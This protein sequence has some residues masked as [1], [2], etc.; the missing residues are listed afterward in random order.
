MLGNLH[1]HWSR[2]PET[3]SQSSKLEQT[4][5]NPKHAPESKCG[6]R[7]KKLLGRN[8][9]QWRCVDHPVSSNVS[10]PLWFFPWCTV[11]ATNGITHKKSNRN[12]HHVLCWQRRPRQNSNSVVQ[13]FYHDSHLAFATP[14]LVKNKRICNG[15]GRNWNRTQIIMR[16]FTTEQTAFAENAC[17]DLK[18]YRQTFRHKVVCRPVG[19]PVHLAVCKVCADRPTSFHPSGQTTRNTH[20]RLGWILELW[21]GHVVSTNLAPDHHDTRNQKHYARTH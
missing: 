8:R 6:F 10:R 16:K 13:K 12:Y 7:W 14:M 21:R 11:S 20:E 5:P 17:L 19:K 3:N 15:C 1:A 18:K 9:F 2:F 4:D